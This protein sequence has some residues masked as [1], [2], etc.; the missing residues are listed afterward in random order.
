MA[1]R[2]TLAV[3]A[4]SILHNSLLM[5]RNLGM[6]SQTDLIEITA[7]YRQKR[8]NNLNKKSDICGLY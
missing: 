7:Y 3:N 2:G 6:I 4:E 1:V 5:L 8:E